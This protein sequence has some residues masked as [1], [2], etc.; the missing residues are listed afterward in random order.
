MYRFFNW[1]E[2]IQVREILENNNSNQM[3]FDKFNFRKY[4]RGF[5]SKLK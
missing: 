1:P 2:F 5:K 4:E 3:S